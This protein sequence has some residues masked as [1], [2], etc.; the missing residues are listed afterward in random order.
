M[1]CGET[2]YDVCKYV[3]FG[4]GLSCRPYEERDKVV[5]LDGDIYFLKGTYSGVNSC[6]EDKQVLTFSL[7]G[8]QSGWFKEALF[9]PEKYPLKG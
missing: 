8:Y 7:I 4:N 6:S 9:H 5:D 2:D 1:T 3:E